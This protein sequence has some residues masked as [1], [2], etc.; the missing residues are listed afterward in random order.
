MQTASDE[1]I[2]S[3]VDWWHAQHATAGG[4]LQCSF[5]GGGAS[6]LSVLGSARQASFTRQDIES[7]FL[8]E[9][10]VDA[11][12]ELTPPARREL[13]LWR[14]TY[15]GR[16]VPPRPSS[17]VPQDGHTW[18]SHCVSL[19]MCVDAF[20]LGSLASLPLILL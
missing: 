17:F 12:D 20:P 15:V 11:E 13:Q 18:A 1:V 7:A 16:P 8:L 3:S 19:Y 9:F 6:D 4:Q 14:T 2:N 10:G 5:N